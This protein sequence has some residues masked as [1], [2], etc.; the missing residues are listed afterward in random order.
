MA[1]RSLC[2]HLFYAAVAVHAVTV[3]NQLGPL[4]AQSTNTTAIST[5]AAL[6]STGNFIGLAAAYN[7]TTWPP[8]ALPDPL[9]ASQFA[10][11]L[12]PTADLVEGISIP[13]P[14][15]FF[16]LSI[17]MSVVTQV[18]KCPLALSCAHGLKCVRDSWHQ[19]VRFSFC[20]MT[21]S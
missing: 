15:S 5:S 10:I 8:P 21:I 11:E 12:M 4:A 9:P 20:W 13:A 2:L 14:G 3:Y 6:T 16:G 7:P 18:R 19:C 1:V 17:E